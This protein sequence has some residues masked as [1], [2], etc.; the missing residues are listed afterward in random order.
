[1]A[2]LLADSTAFVKVRLPFEI[3]V[4]AQLHRES[5]RDRFSLPLSR[6]SSATV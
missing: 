6:G 1:M 2:V 3:R 5:S 4:L